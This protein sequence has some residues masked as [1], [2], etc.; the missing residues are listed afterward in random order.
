MLL[1]MDIEQHHWQLIPPLLFDIVQFVM[2]GEAYGYTPIP[3][4]LAES[5]ITQ[6]VMNDEEY[7]QPIPPPKLA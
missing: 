5:E 3:P 6:F 4:P 7:P 1:V 2:D